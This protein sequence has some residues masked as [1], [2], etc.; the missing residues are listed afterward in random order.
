M[1][2]RS[3]PD[4]GNGPSLTEDIVLNSPSNTITIEQLHAPRNVLGCARV[5]PCLDY[6]LRLLAFLLLYFISFTFLVL[7]SEAFHGEEIFHALSRSVAASSILFFVAFLLL[8]I[9]YL[10]DAS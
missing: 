3:A 6:S 7:F 9:M 8:V 5:G 1:E 4:K 10:F 2:S